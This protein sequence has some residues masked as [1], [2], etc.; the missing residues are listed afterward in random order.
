MAYTSIFFNGVNLTDARNGITAMTNNICR[1]NDITLD[2][3]AII[4]ENSTEVATLLERNIISAVCMA[5]PEY[6]LLRPKV[7]FN[8]LCANVMSGSEETVYVV[9]TQKGSPLRTL[10]DL[11]GKHLALLTHSTMNLATAWLDVALAKQNQPQTTRHLATITRSNKPA[12]VVLPIFFGQIDACLTTRRSYDMMVELNPQVGRQ[13]Q[14]IASSPGYLAF[15]YGFRPD[16]PPIPIAKAHHGLVSMDK[17]ISGLQ[18]LALFQVDKIIQIPDNALDPTFALLDE[19]AR[20]CP[21]ASAELIAT[22]RG[23]AA[24]PTP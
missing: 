21:E 5:T 9:L 16:A 15:F 19:H 17:T 4:Y 24:T 8:L 7:Q 2:G 11:K 18:T 20:L 6:W 3:P 22:L 13:L 23:Q 1:E 10:A 14:I 12:K